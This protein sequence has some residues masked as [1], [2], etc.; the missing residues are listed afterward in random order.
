MKQSSSI[1]KLEGLIWN[2]CVRAKAPDSEDAISKWQEDEY[3]HLTEGFMVL[4]MPSDLN[5]SVQ[6]AIAA[7]SAIE[8]KV[9]CSMDMSRR[10]FL[11]EFEKTRDDFLKNG[12]IWKINA[13]K[14]ADQVYGSVL[15][16]NWVNLF[17]WMLPYADTTN[18]KTHKETGRMVTALFYIELLSKYGDDHDNVYLKRIEARWRIVN[19]I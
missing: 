9:C 17:S 4:P 14:F 1:N 15:N 13:L 11:D 16:M 18:S 2:T 8:E 10:Q 5:E 12:K 6:S 7:W 19:E 3:A